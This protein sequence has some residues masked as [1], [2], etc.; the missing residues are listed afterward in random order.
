M[1]WMSIAVHV[2]VGAAQTPCPEEEAQQE[3]TI[4]EYFDV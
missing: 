2:Y 4:K 1:C 3:L